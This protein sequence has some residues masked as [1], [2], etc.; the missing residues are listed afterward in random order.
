MLRGERAFPRLSLY[1][2]LQRII[3]KISQHFVSGG[4]YFGVFFSCSALVLAFAAPILEFNRSPLAKWCYEYLRLSCHQIPS[5]CLWILGSN[6]GLCLRC[7][8]IYFGFLAS[9]IILMMVSRSGRPLFNKRLLTVTSILVAPLIIDGG[10]SSSTAYISDGFVR[11]ITGILFGIGSSIVLFLLKRR[12][13]D[14][15]I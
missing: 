6:T 7:L 14:K 4:F 5:K 15:A 12:L 13:H 9:A 11:L 1:S 8:G 3:V 2:V 10:I